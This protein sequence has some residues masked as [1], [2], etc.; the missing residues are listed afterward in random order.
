VAVIER[1][2]FVWTCDTCAR[3]IVASTPYLINPPGWRLIGAH[4]HGPNWIPER[5]FCPEC[6]V[7]ARMAD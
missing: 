3:E 6:T 2:T 5:V 1:K 4:G 7:K